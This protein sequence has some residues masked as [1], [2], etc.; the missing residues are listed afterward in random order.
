[1][2]V[3]RIV[4]SVLFLTTILVFHVRAQHTKEFRKD[5]LVIPLKIKIP[6]QFMSEF[7]VGIK[8]NI[9]NA[10]HY[11]KATLYRDEV[12]YS[13][14]QYSAAPVFEWQF[15]KHLSI[16][17]EPTWIQG[18]SRSRISDVN[19]RYPGSEIDWINGAEPIHIQI[20]TNYI[21]LPLLF[22]ARFPIY[23]NKLLF[24]SEIGYSFAWFVSGKRIE[25]PANTALFH[26]T[27]TK[28]DNNNS[29]DINH[30]D[31]GLN[32]GLGLSIPMKRSFIDLNTRYYQGLRNINKTYDSKNQILSYQVGYRFTL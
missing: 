18:V 31:E 14:W 22:K 28:L 1:M 23:K 7:S 30:Y 20:N 21:A 5:S 24:S 32:V 16:G 9:N 17:I 25:T 27:E 2:Q 26:V 15:L 3:K 29:W 13:V 10:F 19:I 11:Y 8:S 6:F 4:V 12:N